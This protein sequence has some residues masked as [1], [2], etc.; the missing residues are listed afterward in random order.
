MELMVSFCVQSDLWQEDEEEEEEQEQE[1][2]T[3]YSLNTP[4]MHAS[5]HSEFIH[6]V[7]Q[8][9]LILAALPPVHNTSKVLYVGKYPT[10]LG[11]R[12]QIVPFDFW[13]D[14]KKDENA[15]DK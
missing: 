4:Q 12:A 11:G 9:S 13:A 6:S 3:G 7:R 5:L 10:P 8:F 15:K 1:E 14:M 2:Q